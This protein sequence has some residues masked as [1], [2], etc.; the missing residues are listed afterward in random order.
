MTIGL[1]ACS[2]N[3]SSSDGVAATT[4][5][6]DGNDVIVGDI[7]INFPLVTEET[8]LNVV[9][10]GYGDV[11]ADSVYVWEKYDEMTGIDIN[12]TTI[13]K[14]QRDETVATTLM[15]QS[16]IDLLLR[17]KVSSSLLTQYGES[18]LIVDL[19]K[20]DL[21]ATYAPNCWAYLQ[22][23]PD[24]LAAVTS[25]NG[26]IYALPQVNSG[27]E[28]RVSRKIFVNK[29]WL[30]RV[31]M[32]LP[33]TTEEFYQLLKAFKDQDANGN[34]DTE[35]EIP[36]SSQDF[37]SIQEALY[38]AFG[39]ANRGIHNQTVDVNEKTGELR[40]LQSSD[41]Y[42]E[43]LKY[44]NKLYS[45]GL[46]DQYI[47]T[48]N[49]DQWYNYA[50]TDRLGV[51]V[52][53][54]LATLP[55]DTTDNWVA[56][57]VALEGPN[58]DKLWTAIRA[59]FHST[60]AAIIPASCEHPELVLQWL[61]YFWTD[62]GTLFYH[63]GI[64]SETYNVNED[65]S[66]DYSQALYDEMENKSFDD[67]IAT[68]SPYPGGNNP[69]VEIAPYFKGGE[70]ADIPAEAARKLF[71]YGPEEYWPSFTF[72]TEEGERLGVVETDMNKYCSESR[73]S[74]ITGEKSFDEWDE[75]LTQI[76]K[77]G[78]GEVLKIY[79]A[80]VERYRAIVSSHEE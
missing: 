44:F 65:G 39:L 25:P 19:A 6:V 78:G 56:I 10:S 11:S 63:M 5:S 7:P 61:D 28:L 53:T 30:E 51:F 50:D 21:M 75:Y 18:G 32:E 20:D 2:E 31:G 38:G 62:A 79:K 15:N 41:E 80:A 26:A 37:L 57:N 22:T 52:S 77:L 43:Y 69:T 73:I 74:F 23:H 29:E 67:V 35:D 17:C 59:N 13:K 14:S 34:G 66:F 1:V 71:E 54:N 48:I 12:W 58:G 76:D 24:A 42:R 4:T 72:T 46:L 47:F 49:T 60:G 27:A 70:M 33:T 64:E 3:G 16:N 45:E 55:S 40:L 9:F 8:S 36:L 68:Y